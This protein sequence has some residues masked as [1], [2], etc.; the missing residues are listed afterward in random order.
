MKHFTKQQLRRQNVVVLVII[1]LVIIACLVTHQVF[2]QSLRPVNPSDPAIVRVTVPRGA[3]D[4][5]VGVLLKQHHLVRSAYVF[6]Y[7]LQTHKT[8]G[9]KAGQFKMTRKMSTPQIVRNIQKR[10]LAKVK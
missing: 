4:K 8:T 10:Q 9:V 7:Y 2:D 1:A 3:T 6:D 5:E